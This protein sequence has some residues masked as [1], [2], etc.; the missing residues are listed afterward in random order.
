MKIHL[1]SFSLHLLSDIF[2]LLAC[3]RAF[4]FFIFLP[5]CRRI[6]TA[7]GCLDFVSPPF[8][9]EKKEDFRFDFKMKIHFFDRLSSSC[10]N[11]TVCVLLANG[12]VSTVFVGI[13]F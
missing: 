6:S 3:V 2:F 7:I 8:I 5:P 1:A 11:G 4:D 10:R 13:L 9:F 12:N